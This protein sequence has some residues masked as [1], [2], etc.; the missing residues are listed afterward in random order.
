MP[1]DI[2]RARL[3]RPLPQ[4]EDVAFVAVRADHIGLKLIGSL[5]DR[6]R[7]RRPAHS[8]GEIVGA[9]HY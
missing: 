6:A 9:S 3:P 4:D 8:D 5:T 1:T 7:L 2:G